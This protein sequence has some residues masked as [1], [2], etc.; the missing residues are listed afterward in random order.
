[1]TGRVGWQLS[2][3]YPGRRCIRRLE[4]HKNWGYES[5]AGVMGLSLRESESRSVEGSLAK[6]EIEL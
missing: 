5:M 2:T 6:D 3:A 4:P 1:V